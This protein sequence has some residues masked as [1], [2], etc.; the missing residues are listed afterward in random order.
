MAIWAAMRSAT[1]ATPRAETVA[2]ETAAKMR[3]SAAT[4]LW[5]LGRTATRDRST[6]TMS[7]TPAEQ[8]AELLDAA[9]ASW[10]RV[11]DVTTATPRTT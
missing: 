6:R 9:T 10:T 8:T 5:I 3:P 11:S 1:T 4:G 2:G 7:R